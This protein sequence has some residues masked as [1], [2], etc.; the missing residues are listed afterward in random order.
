MAR[1]RTVT[2]SVLILLGDKIVQRFE[3]TEKEDGT[4]TAAGTL[5][6]QYLMQVFQDESHELHEALASKQLEMVNSQVET[7]VPKTKTKVTF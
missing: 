3:P 6:K 5:A 2:N 7:I 1:T 4:V